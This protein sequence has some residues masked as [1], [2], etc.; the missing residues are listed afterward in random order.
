MET[1]KV[2]RSRL[3][4]IKGL[5]LFIIIIGILAISLQ[6]IT[7][8]TDWFWFQEVGYQSVFYVTLLAKVKMA[9]LFGVVFFAIFYTNLF[10]A[11][12]FSS[13]LFVIEGDDT[14]QMPP[15][16]LSNKT[17]Q[18]LIIAASLFFTVFA[19]SSGTLQWESFL[20]FTHASSFGVSDP[21]GRE[22]PATALFSM[23]LF[24]IKFPVQLKRRSRPELVFSDMSLFCM[25]FPS[26]SLNI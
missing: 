26:Q 8:I 13:R 7:L 15:W 10:L 3:Q 19:A 18:I 23:V 9:A 25:T 12:R 6:F 2:P 20:L 4:S 24:S 11:V 17:S 1:F 21:P 5:A 16:E 22:I 14:I